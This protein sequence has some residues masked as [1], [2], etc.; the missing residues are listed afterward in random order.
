MRG[1]ALT[2]V[3]IDQLQKALLNCYILKLHKVT[4]LITP[5]KLHK[6][7]GEPKKSRQSRALPCDIKIL[8]SLKLANSKTY[9]WL[10]L[11]EQLL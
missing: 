7:V 2:T 6:R 1:C 11:C 5:V 10:R 8:L 9:S 3:Q 4:A